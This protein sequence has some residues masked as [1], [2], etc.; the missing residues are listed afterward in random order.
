MTNKENVLAI[1]SEDDSNTFEWA[2]A[3]VANEELSR[4]GQKVAVLI[5]K[6]LKELGWSQKELAEKMEISPQLVNKWVKGKENDF[7]LEVLFRIGDYLGINLIKKHSSKYD[8]RGFI[9]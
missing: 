4:A 3:Q 2:K 6:R 5:L 8:K 7:S 1:V 9:C